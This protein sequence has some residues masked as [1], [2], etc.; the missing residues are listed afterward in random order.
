[1]ND[2]L[3]SSKSVWFYT[4]LLSILIVLGS[5]LY[6]KTID[7]P[8]VFDDTQHIV[9][10]S[11]IR[12]N[13]ISWEQ[14]KK[15]VAQSRSRHIPHLSFAANYYFNN[16][17]VSGYHLVNILIHIINGFLLFIFTKKTIL[18]TIEP[19]ASRDPIKS[20]TLIPFFAA[21][22]WF[23]H[24]VNTQ[25][26]SYIVQRMNSM[27]ALFYL[28]SALMYI[29]GREVQK[30]NKTDSSSRN[31]YAK[32]KIFFF[33]TSSIAF[34]LLAVD[35][36][37]NAITLPIFVLSHELFFFQNL[38]I[39]K[40]I[41]WISSCLIIL[42][43]ISL[44]LLKTDALEKIFSIYSTQD[45][46]LIQRL[47]TEPRV[48]LYYISLFFLPIP[49]RL[50]L[51]YNYPISKSLLVPPT[52]ILSILVIVII[53]Y[54]SLRIAR[55]EKLLAFSFL[56]YLGALS[57]ESSVIG[58]AIIFEHRT[59]LPFM[60]LSLLSADLLFRYAKNKIITIGFLS[61]IIVL[62]SIW[63]YQ[64]NT[65][66]QSPYSL[67]SDNL[68]KTE[69]FRLHL[70]MGVTL[71]SMGNAHDALLHYQKA[72]KLYP[73]YSEALY[74]TGNI[75][76]DVPNYPKAIYYYQKAL[77][78]I[79]FDYKLKNPKIGADIYNNLGSIMMNKNN[80]YSAIEY[81]KKALQIQPEKT[82]TLLNLGI[83][84][85]ALNKLD[86]AISTLQT[87]TNKSKGSPL[88]MDA[89][90]CLALLFY[91][92]GRYQEALRHFKIHPNY[93]D[94]RYYIDEIVSIHK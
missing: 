86:L 52:T 37:E 42:I 9:E 74:N 24:P 43:G 53:I 22:I 7:A 54:F 2:F 91:K 47:L 19:S 27:A 58:L 64:R 8:F 89:H 46:N 30:N 75:F 48:V 71:S 61:A 13:E 23:V 38:Q 90:Y 18:L 17:D 93:K 55:K 68:K 72:L 66:W 4:G 56:W 14:I 49:S 81:Y 67:Y 50:M 57:I 82:I 11:F 3:K 44:I 12:I 51:E 80:A 5:L 36:K 25:S 70:N 76:R 60:F 73:Y 15:T 79:P 33:F 83:A 16:Y 88:N 78:S 1:M 32:F 41:Y 10:N 29:F 59:Y 20:Q 45:F 69:F 87:C 65:V 34:G 94:T 84:Y 39:K 28:L 40:I 31:F 6:L 26:V 35:S 63:T 92:Q 62:F 21:L 85:S 77:E